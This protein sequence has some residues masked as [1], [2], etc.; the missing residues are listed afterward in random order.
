MNKLAC[1]YAIL[2]FLPYTETGEFANVGVVLACPAT[3]YFGFKLETRRYARLTHFFRELDRQVYLRAIGAFR[4]E[5]ERLRKVNEQVR[6]T[7]LRDAFTAMLHP[8][9]AIL[10]FGEA[11]ALLTGDPAQ[12]VEQLFARYVEHDFVQ[13]EAHEKEME[14]KVQQ[15]IKGLALEHPFREERV[16]DD[17]YA[18]RFP[19]VQVV[20]DRPKKI[21]KPFFLAQEDSNA[22]FNH[23]DAWLAKL[24][25]LK[26]RHALPK[27]VLFTVKGPEKGDR[28]RLGAFNEVS[29]ELENYADVARAVDK[30]EIL[31]FVETAP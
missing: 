4:D 30:A 8:R 21:I 22:I 9:E 14:H 2:R 3:G 10:R 31:R 20:N 17:E 19:F 6:D 23:G 24:K 11:R 16:G 18:V 25:R 29:K 13:H 26:H 28:K 1:R 5:L 7:A 15:M 27:H 12:A